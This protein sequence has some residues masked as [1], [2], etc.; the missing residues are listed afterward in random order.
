[1]ARRFFLVDPTRLLRPPAPF[2]SQALPTNSVPSPVWQGTY[3]ECL[4]NALVLSS[5]DIPNHYENSASGVWSIFVP[6]ELQEK[7]REQISAYQCENA[8]A[9]APMALPPLLLSRQPFWVLAI[10]LIPTWLAFLEVYPNMAE[11]GMNHVAYTLH[12]E[13]WRIF[14]ALTLH[15]D[16]NHLAGNLLSGYFVLSLLANRIP[17][18]RIAP[19]LFAAAG[20]ANLVVAFTVT[21]DFRS[22]GF[23]TYVFASL[24]ALASIEWR[25]RP[26]Q[27]QVSW[28]KRAE[29]ILSAFFL[30]VMMGLGEN[31]DVLAHF[32]GFVAGILTGLLP[33]RASIQG[34]TV[35]WERSDVVAAVCTALAMGMCW[36]K[37]LSI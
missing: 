37:A 1:M 9:C 26:Q 21:K 17:L 25:N 29:P 3:G 23:S 24:G 10:P 14:T 28:L 16:A 18:T 31:S 22:L 8:D 34:R 11:R 2:V 4:E 27:G 36:W 20:L 33:P 6:E 35:T 15:A 12:G 7:A 32:Y 5:Q 30:T 13:W 19:L